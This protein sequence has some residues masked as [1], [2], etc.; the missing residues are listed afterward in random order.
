MKYYH[1]NT[2]TH[3]E[4]DTLTPVSVDVGTCDLRSLL[5]SF[6]GE[7]LILD[8]PLISYI[9]ALVGGGMQEAQEVYHSFGV[10]SAQKLSELVHGFISIVILL[11]PQN[12]QV[13]YK[14]LT[15]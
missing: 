1:A 14:Y 10:R 3:R 5:C 15:D 13:Q 6:P 9:S 11:T 4:G 12:D 2:H 7:K 8:C